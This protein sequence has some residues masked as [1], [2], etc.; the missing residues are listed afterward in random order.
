MFPELNQEIEKLNYM[1]HRQ[2]KLPAFFIIVGIITTGSILFTK[3]TRTIDPDG[4]TAYI[5]ETASEP[6]PAVT[7]SNLLPELPAFR[8]FIAF[9]EQ[10]LDSSHT[11]GA[12]YTIVHNGEV[13]Y[14]ST[15]GERK[16]GNS[17]EVDEHTL[18]GFGP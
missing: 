15:Y 4:H 6:V 1:K 13:T 7:D 2:Y 8:D 14:T 18:G 10:E 16:R 9:M 5:G 12:A 3:G 17:D 11:V